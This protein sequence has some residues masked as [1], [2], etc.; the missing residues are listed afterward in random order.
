MNFPSPAKNFPSPAKCQRKNVSGAL[1]SL[2]RGEAT[3]LDCLAHMAE[4]GS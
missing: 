3:E 2:L 4:A 1:L